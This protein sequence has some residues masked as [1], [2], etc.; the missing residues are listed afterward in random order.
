MSFAE[1]GDLPFDEAIRFL[2]NKLSVPTGRWTDVWKQGHDQAFMVA[3][4]AKADLLQDLRESVDKAVSEGETLAAFRERFDEIVAEH[5]WE[6]NGPR[7]WRTR[8]IYETNLRT[9]WQA[10]R[11]AQLTDPDVRE[12]RPYWQYRH[13]GSADPRAEHLA[14]D[15]TVLPADDP[16]WDAHYPPNGWGCS[17]HVVALSPRDL[18]NMGV[19]VQEAPEV[20]TYEWTDPA[21]GEVHEVPKGL[22]PGWD[23]APGRSVA[24]RTR[25]TI[26]RKAAKLPDDLGENLRRHADDV[27]DQDPGPAPGDQD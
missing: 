13:G 27:A 9:S 19:E 25:E 21:T 20:E 16:W 5:G 10:G 6:Y 22:D 2:R 4:A 3:G 15:G 7:N 14:W 26:E 24:E 17:C 23:Y 1:Y 18:E 12:R 8:V 11:Y